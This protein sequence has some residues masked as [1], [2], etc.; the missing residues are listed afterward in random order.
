MSKRRAWWLIGLSIALLVSE[1]AVV[2]RATQAFELPLFGTWMSGAVLAMTGPSDDIAPRIDFPLLG[3]L[4]VLGFAVSLALARSTPQRYADAGKAGLAVLAGWVM[5]AVA[6]IVS[7]IVQGSETFAAVGWG[8]LLLLDPMCYV[9]FGLGG[10]LAVMALRA[11]IT[12]L[13]AGSLAGASPNER[14][15]GCA[16]S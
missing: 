10:V 15:D 1:L 5:V 11:G 3:M 13:R 8:M 6:T 12:L 16:E 2:V 9:V 7:V 14:A 4:L